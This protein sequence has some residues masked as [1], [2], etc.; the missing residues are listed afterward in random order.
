MAQA[1]VEEGARKDL[2]LAARQVSSKRA[3]AC[4]VFRVGE[5]DNLRFSNNSD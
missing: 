5:S 1:V 2:F 4:R 3:E